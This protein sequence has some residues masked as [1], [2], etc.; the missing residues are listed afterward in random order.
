LSKVKPEDPKLGSLIKLIGWLDGYRALSCVDPLRIESVVKEYPKHDL[1]TMWREVKTDV[2]KIASLPASS[3]EI[4]RLHKIVA[5]SKFSFLMLAMVSMTIWIAATR[6]STSFFGSMFGIVLLALL[7]VLYN[8]NII[9]YVVYNRRMYKRVRAY[10]EEHSK[11][12]GERRK[13][14]KQ[15]TQQLI[16]KLA[17]YIKGQGYNPEKYEF[18]LF[19]SDYDNIKIVGE[20]RNK[21]F[22]I[23]KT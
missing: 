4:V 8:A 22:A 20:K 18:S 10:Y 7:A 9:I 11:E 13:R 19:H 14:I 12:L 16:D 5:I 23:I 3:P 17:R 15:A 21:H 1:R 2:Y 6:V